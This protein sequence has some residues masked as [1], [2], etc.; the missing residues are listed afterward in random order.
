MLRTAHS[1]ERTRI[2]PR[3]K[4]TALNTET[5]KKVKAGTANLKWEG[6]EATKE[7]PQNLVRCN[8]VTVV[9]VNDNPEL[10]I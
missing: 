10:V 5:L 3:R 7:E 8:F 1:W 9:A 6:I 4:S 2:L